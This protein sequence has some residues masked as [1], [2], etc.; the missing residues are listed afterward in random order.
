[1]GDGALIGIGAKVL[2]GA[3]IGPG[4]IV[5]AGAL[6]PEGMEVPSNTLVMGTPAKAKRAVTAEEQARFAENCD[7]YVKI[8][9]I[10][11]EEQQ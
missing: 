1:V 3:K 5:A 10:Y 9:A 8:T 11:K 7:N 4:S 6:V 2:N